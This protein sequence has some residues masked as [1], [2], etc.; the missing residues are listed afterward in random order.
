MLWKVA[1]GALKTRGSLGRRLNQE[2]EE[3]FL[4]PL[5]KLARILRCLIAFVV[6]K[7]LNWAMRWNELPIANPAELVNFILH[8]DS[9]LHIPKA[10]VMAFCL[11]AAV[12]MDVFW[13]TRNKVVHQ[14]SPV[15]T[16][17][18]ALEVRRQYGEH[19]KA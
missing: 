13:H 5:C 4:C 7:E 8:A 19:L 2:E 11:N 12:V 6:W 17:N 18:L 1:A 10:D 15:I 14:A 3:E 9:R 16:A